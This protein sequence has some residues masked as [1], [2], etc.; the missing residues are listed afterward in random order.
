MWSSIYLIHN[1]NSP[2]RR[3]WT[4]PHQTRANEN[5]LTVIHTRLSFTVWRMSSV[6]MTGLKIRQRAKSNAAF[7]DEN[8]GI[9]RVGASAGLQ[10]NL[11]HDT[12]INKFWL[13]PPLSGTE[14]QLDTN[15]LKCKTQKKNIPAC[16]RKHTRL[17][18]YSIQWIVLIGEDVA[19]LST[20]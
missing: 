13:S 5:K 2:K 7:G 10:I 9:A 14:G 16:A 8:K 3:K 12:S 6:R 15:L 11:Q 4:S 18:K 1:M 17:P 19:A 20:T